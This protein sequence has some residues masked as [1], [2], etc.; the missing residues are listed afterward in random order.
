[1]FRISSAIAFGRQSI[2]TVRVVYGIRVVYDSGIRYTE[3]IRKWYTIVVYGIRKVYD[4]GIRYTTVVY[5]IPM[6]YGRCTDGILWY[7][8]GIRREKRGE[9]GRGEMW[10]YKESNF[11]GALILNSDLDESTS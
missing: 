4:S 6:V 9:N 1:M 11:Y 7:T 8:G 5:G 3:G 2:N 10:V